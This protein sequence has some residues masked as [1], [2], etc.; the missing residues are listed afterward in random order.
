MHWFQKCYSFRS[1]TKNNEVIAENL[2]PV[3]GLASPGAWPSRIDARRQYIR[4]VVVVVIIIITITISWSVWCHFR[5]RCHESESLMDLDGFAVTWPTLTMLTMAVE[6]S[7]SFSDARSLWS[8]RNNV[9]YFD[10]WL[11]PEWTVVVTSIHTW[12]ASYKRYRSADSTVQSDLLN[13]IRAWMHKNW[14]LNFCY[15]YQNS[16]LHLRL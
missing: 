13:S 14:G 3:P 4:L 5:H 8:C 1:T 6:N 12:A 11:A 9:M 7:F 15:R 10:D 16:I 2:K